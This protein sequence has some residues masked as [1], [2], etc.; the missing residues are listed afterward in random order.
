MTSNRG[1]RR[2]FLL[3]PANMDGLR[4]RLLLSERAEF[5]LAKRLRNGGAPLGEVFSFVSG[6]YFR[7]K[8]AYA[9]AFAESCPGISGAL[10]ITGCGGLIP[11]DRPITPEQLQ[12]FSAT[13]LDPSDCRYRGPLVRDCRVLSAAVGAG[14]QVVLLGS[15]ATPK[16]LDPLLEVFAERLFFPSEFIGRGD[17]S[18]GGLM[19]R[20]VRAGTQLSYVPAA[21]TVLH[22]PKPAKLAAIPRGRG[23]TRFG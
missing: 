9:E 5:D 3:S 19:L 22:G 6:L 2:I 1:A 18:R 14:C 8:L 7:G 4:F 11:P 13:D 23:E 20:S 17:L 12:T 16:Y 15:I 21:E 10:V